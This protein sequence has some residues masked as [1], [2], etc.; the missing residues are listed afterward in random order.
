M[1]QNREMHTLAFQTRADAQKAK[2]LFEKIQLD[3][4]QAGRAA[5]LREAFE[6]ACKVIC[7]ACRE[8]G[9]GHKIWKS[10]RYIDPCWTI[11]RA[12][13]QLGVLMDKGEQDATTHSR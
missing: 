6:A 13:A 2:E 3:L 4:Y 8:E 7:R 1:Y 11:R 5:G 10:G 9:V 12:A